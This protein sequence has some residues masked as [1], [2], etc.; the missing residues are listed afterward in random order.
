MSKISIIIP[1][2]QGQIYLEEC[3]ESIE[4][5]QLS[6]YEI[7]VVN[8]RGGQE[9]PT[10][11]TEKPQVMVYHAIE[12]RQE[13][14]ISAGE[15][16][17][18]EDAP[19]GVACCRNIGIAKATGKY[20]YFIDCD[21]YLLEGALNRLVALA[22]EKA[23]L[24]TTGNKYSSWFKPANFNFDRGT[25]ETF[26]QGI[27][28]MT[29]QALSDRF[30]AMFSVQHLLIQRKFLLE[31]GIEFDEEI[32]YYSDMRFVVQALQAAGEQM[33]LDGD[34]LYVWRHH[35]DRI[36]L[37]A[38]SQKKSSGRGREF[39]DSYSRS[40]EFLTQKDAVLRQILDRSLVRFSLSKFPGQIRGEQAVRYTKAMQKMP[41][42]KNLTKEFRR[43][44]RLEMGFVRR[45]KYRLAKP[46]SKISTRLRKKNGLFGS[47]I[48]WYLMLEK[49]IF[50]KMSIRHDWIFIESFFGKSYSDSPKYLYEY[51][52]KTRGDKYRYIWVLNRNSPDLKKTGKYTRCKMYSLRYIYYA[53]RS[54]YRIFNVRQPMW[55]KKRPGVIF[56]QTWHGTPLKRLAFDLDDIFAASQN[57]K[58]QFY[59]Q[60]REWDYLVSANEFST[61]VFERAFVYNRDKILEYGYP[62]NDILYA[63][64][65]EE[66]AA[67]VK[68]EF[69]IP[70]DKRVILY[71]PTWRDDQFYGKGRYKFHLAMDL[72]LMRREFSED[73]VILLRTHYH[74]ADIVDLSG[75]KGFVYNGSKYEDVSR[76]YLASDICITDY[77]SVFFDYANLKRPILFFTYD[78]ESYAD[79]IRGLYIDMEKELPGPV[80][81]TNEAVVEALHNM[82]AINETYHDRYEEFYR[83]FCS[84]DDGHAA[85]RIIETVFGK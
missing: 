35:N 59:E 60:A 77:S 78:Y 16:E 12:E 10:S 20:V 42:W 83:R 13:D 79:E 47:K 41:D 29:G 68:K 38:L 74:I 34:S 2:L 85:E 1:Y 82:D 40:L 55:C 54:G 7:I 63:D 58:M 3:V 25:Q 30:V 18:D 22:E 65:R 19:L 62:R 45:G 50:R 69:G 75:Y 32:T 49:Y 80:L 67:E 15:E 44:E 70:E 31:K 26:I 64:N 71:A 11:V 73:S 27:Q 21:D 39:M 48:Q 76:L 8:D 72:D 61:D 9:V 4:D 5:Q 6:D 37:P 84:V 33:W 43:L 52:K 56:L 81:R 17:I 23:A 46:V 14:K 66:I 24:I 57:H 28:Q 36:H 53:A 51:L